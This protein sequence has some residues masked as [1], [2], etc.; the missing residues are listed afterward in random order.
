MVLVSEANRREIVE[1]VKHSSALEGLYAS[2]EQE[3][4]MELW[5]QDKITID[6]AIQLTLD[7]YRKD[8]SSAVE[9]KD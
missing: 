3:E 9:I 2:P 8:E 1:Q 4:L 7:R 6:E 5:I